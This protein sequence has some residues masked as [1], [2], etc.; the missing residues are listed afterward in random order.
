MKRVDSKG[1]TLTG[2]GLGWENSPPQLWKIAAGGR[3]GKKKREKREKRKEERE[4]KEKEGKRKE[5]E[6]KRR[7]GRENSKL[8]VF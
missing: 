3:R 1:H 7:K 4:K 2:G 5:K 8:K 6:E